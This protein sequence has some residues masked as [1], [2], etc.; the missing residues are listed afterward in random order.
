M[1]VGA[2]VDHLGRGETGGSLTQSG[3]RRTT[4]HGADD[5]A[6]GVAALIEI[7]E[8][9]A[10]QRVSGE[11][12]ANRN[13]V[14]A[15]WSGEELGLLGSRS[16]LDASGTTDSKRLYAGYLNMDMI[17]RLRERVTVAGMGSSSG[18][19]EIVADANTNVG[20]TLETIQ[21]PYVPTDAMTFYLKG[22]PVLSISTGA[23]SEYH[24]PPGP[25]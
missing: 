9:L 23:N 8:L 20:L 4:H 6:S 3:D 12:F 25:A 11:I 1:V 19:A 15:A 7:A 17:G 21:T 24:T 18:W 10:A 5:N 14:F 22:V 16:F 13:I 2:H